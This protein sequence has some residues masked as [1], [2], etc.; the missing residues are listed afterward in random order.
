MAEWKQYLCDKSKIIALRKEQIIQ[1]NFIESIK[2]VPMK[3]EESI[4]SMEFYPM[5][6]SEWCKEI[7]F[8]LQLYNMLGM[9]PCW[10]I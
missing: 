8:K 6:N 1:H 3:C 7:S 9:Q 4:V 2:N 10:E 5:A